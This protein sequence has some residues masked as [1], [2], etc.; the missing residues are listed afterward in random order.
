MPKSHRIRSYHFNLGNST[1]GHVGYCASVIATSKVHAV[2][3]LKGAIG[4]EAKIR[5]VEGDE[6]VEY[7]EVYFNPDKISVA[8]IDE[9]NDP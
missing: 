6:R 5:P 1:D 3:I 8:D 9:V 2:R 4:L 7:I